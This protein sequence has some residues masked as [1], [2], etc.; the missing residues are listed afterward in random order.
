MKTL[1]QGTTIPLSNG[2]T[3]VVKSLLGEGGQGAVYLAQVDGK[4]YALKIYAKR[5]SKKFMLN[6]LDN[7]R[8]G[9]PTKHFLWPKWMVNSPVY[10]GYV[11][12][13]RPKEYIEFSRFLIAKARFASWSAL[14]NGAMEITYAFRELHRAGLS[15]QD[16]N[17]GNFF[18]NPKTGSVLI[19]DNDNV[20]PPD[21]NLGIRGKFRYMAPEVILCKNNP[22]NLSDYFSL[23]VILFML[24]MNNHPLD[25]RRVASVPCLNDAIERHVYGEHPIFIYDLKDDSN[26]PVSGVHTNVRQRWQLFPQFVRDTF[27]KQFSAEVMANPNKRMADNEWL[28]VLQQLRNQTLR[29]DCGYET[30]AEVGSGTFCYTCGKQLGKPLTLS[31]GKQHI[32]LYPGMCLYANQTSAKDDAFTVTGE[33]VRNAKD[34]YVWGIINRSQDTWTCTLPDGRTV[35]IESNMGFP[36][37]RGMD[38][39]F[40]QTRNGKIDRVIIKPDRVIM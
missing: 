35:N 30:F 17:D 22:N 25:G 20:C 10:S 3:A 5:P 40:S 9:A 39:Q 14:I 23:S 8:K 24:L 34:P 4:D 6:L 32:A 33:V 19:C 2:S 11:M 12:D 37:Y 13:V 21:T 28:K 16:L 26:R 27:F 38:V 29:C 36:I 15:Y 31:I 7:I 18:F 1:K